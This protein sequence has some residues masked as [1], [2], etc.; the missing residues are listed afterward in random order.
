M[1]HTHHVHEAMS[2]L[3][4]HSCYTSRGGAVGESARVCM[5]RGCENL[6]ARAE[7]AQVDQARLPAS[8]HPRFCP[9]LLPLHAVSV[10]II[11]VAP[12][13]QSVGAQLASFSSRLGF[14][15]LS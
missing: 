9:C 10:D 2:T 7:V 8:D 14:S 11:I 6:G 13:R 1:C 4:R 15:F 3:L 5:G 12:A